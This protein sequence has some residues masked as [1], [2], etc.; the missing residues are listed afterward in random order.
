MFIPWNVVAH[1]TKDDRHISQNLDPKH[2]LAVSMLDY[3]PLA[4]QYIVDTQYNW[5]H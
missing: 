4:H 5:K 1:V 2:A 3:P